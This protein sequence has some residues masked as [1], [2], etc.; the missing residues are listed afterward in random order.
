MYKRQLIR[1]LGHDDA[2]RV[3]P[4][5]ISDWCD[6]LTVNQ[7]INPRTVSQKYLAVAKLIYAIG[8]EKRKIK[9]N[10]AKDSKV[11]YSKPRRTR[12][13]GF[14]DAEALAILRATFA[15]D[16]NHGRRTEEN[17]RAI[18]WLPWI[19]A[20]TGAR[21]TEAAQLRTIDLIEEGGNLRIRINGVNVFKPSTGQ[22]QFDGPEGIACWF[23]DTDYNE[24]SFFVRHAYFLGSGDP[25]KALKTTLRAEVDEEAWNT[26][27]SDTS[28]PFP[29]PKTGRIAV[30][31]INHLGD[32]VMKVNAV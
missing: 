22:V 9:D 32:E 27:N 2:E 13:R 15:D 30:K 24:E 1:F 31:V 18:R 20:F 25:Y 3:T 23:I 5:N 10:P 6:D 16:G 26:L 4:V 7:C 29:R 19:C 17:R 12:P 21:I 8:V 14:T 28:R 11:R